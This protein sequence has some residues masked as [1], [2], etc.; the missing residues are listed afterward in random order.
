MNMQKVYSAYYTHVSVLVIVFFFFFPVHT[1]FLPVVN[2]ICFPCGFLIYSVDIM[3]RLCQVPGVTVKSSLWF[4]WQKCFYLLWVSLLTLL[5]WPI[6][7]PVQ[8]SALS[9]WVTYDLFS[10]PRN[11]PVI[12]A[13]ILLS[14]SLSP[15]EALSCHNPAVESCCV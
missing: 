13:V 9:A 12:Q 4:D 2:V 1:V 6:V 8:A 15:A 3:C 10:N 14:L 7:R 11:S 5:C